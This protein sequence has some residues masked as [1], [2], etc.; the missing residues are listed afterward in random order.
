VHP[1]IQALLAADRGEDPLVA[2][3]N[4]ARRFVANAMKLGWKGPPFD[5]RKLA[6]M[7]G[8]SV[9]TSTQFEDD[10]DACILP[11]RIV[12]NARRA[13]ARQR[14]SVAHEMIH[15]LFPDYKR[16]LKR[17]GR[18]WR[19]QADDSELEQLCQIAAAEV[20]MPYEAFQERAEKYGRDMEGLVRL[21]KEFDSSVEAAARRL[22]STTKEAMVALFLRPVDVT[23]A[24]LNV[25]DADQH[26]PFATIVVSFVCANAGCA[27][28]E[29]TSGTA[30][31]R[32]GSAE[33]AWKRTTLA[34][35]EIKIEQSADESWEHSGVR[36]RWVSESITLPKGNAVPREV[37]CLLRGRADS[38]PST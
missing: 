16:T 2:I 24:W 17:E 30:P 1:S 33:R 28:F 6:R 15:T 38:V 32:G 9:E 12:V 23:G 34:R 26:D 3:Q 37:L 14:Y 25:A 22:V 4:R 10:Q 19:R 21:A 27:E 18:L 31:P 35:G 36:G 7:R 5:M 13:P 8:Y 11:G 29:A 20:L